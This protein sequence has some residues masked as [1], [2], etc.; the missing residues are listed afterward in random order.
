MDQST[1]FL[2]LP[3]MKLLRS[4]FATTATAAS[5]IWPAG[6]SATTVERPEPAGDFHAQLARGV[7][8]LDQDQ[9]DAAKAVFQALIL[10]HP[11]RPEAYNNLAVIYAAEGSLERAKGLLE[12]AL[13]THPS[14]ATVHQNLRYLEKRSERPT[15]APLAALG[16]RWL[17]QPGRAGSPVSPS[18]LHIPT[19]APAPS[20][21]RDEMASASRV[22][23]IR[24]ALEQWR[25]AWADRDLASYLAS[26]IPDYSPGP[27]MTHAQWARQRSQRIQSKKAIELTLSD[28]KIRMISDH[29]AEAEFLQH[30]RAGGP[31]VR[32]RKT[33]TLVFQAD[34]W[35]IQHERGADE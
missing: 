6:S 24:Q 28:I 2:T 5:L 32:T 17:E 34:R 27:L 7:D 22:L 15:A 1:L 19:S 25:Q 16:L 4:L 23:Q 9:P 12:F 3:G 20:A 35:L 31:P 29:L 8:L 14:Y 13:M 33:L 26:Y 21:P 18:I 10:E 30:Y 11:G